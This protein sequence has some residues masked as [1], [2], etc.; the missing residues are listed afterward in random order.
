MGAPSVEA[1]V[2]LAIAEQEDSLAARF[3]GM[4]RDLERRARIR[5]LKPLK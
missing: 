3:V 4:T 1:S 5:K 2:L